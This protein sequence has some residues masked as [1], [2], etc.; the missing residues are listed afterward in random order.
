M[1]NAVVRWV[2]STVIGVAVGVAVAFALSDRA[3]EPTDPMATIPPADS[4]TE[5]VVE[6]FA[7][8]PIYVD[9]ALGSMLSEDDRADLV[10][11]I[12]GYDLPTFVAVVRT[13]H[14]DG[15]R[16]FL[17]PR[18]IRI[19]ND[20]GVDGVYVAVDQSREA[21]AAYVHDGEVIQDGFFY[22]DEGSLGPALQS[23]VDEVHDSEES[24][25]H[26]RAVEFTEELDAPLTA[27]SIIGGIVLGLLAAGTAY[28]L[29]MLVAGTVRAS[30]GLPFRPPTARA[31]TSA[32]RRKTATARDRARATRGDSRR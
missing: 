11:H 15:F 1:K 9:P 16:S 12:D 8:S 10:A 19:A 27:G 26:A 22:L 5:A 28:G 17:H 23:I 20:A 25:S 13:G 2:V 31:V 30:R 21:A 4:T 18:I 6:E 24:N 3:D 7:S 29:L 32:S 14:D